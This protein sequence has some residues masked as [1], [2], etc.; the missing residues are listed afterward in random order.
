[1]K[2]KSDFV[3]CGKNLQIDDM[4]KNDNE[5]YGTEIAPSSEPLEK[6]MFSTTGIIHARWFFPSENIAHNREELQVFSLLCVLEIQSRKRGICPGP[7][8]LLPLMNDN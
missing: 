5:N 7:L 6:I 4:K 8:P 3:W 2:W 1:M